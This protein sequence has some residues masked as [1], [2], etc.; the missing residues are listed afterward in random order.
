MPFQSGVLKRCVSCDAFVRDGAVVCPACRRSMDQAPAAIERTT[1]WLRLDELEVP[2]AYQRHQKDRLVRHIVRNYDEAQIGLLTVC[3][4]EDGRQW[5][6]DG[7]HRWLAL[8]EMGRTTALCEVLHRLSLERQAEVFSGRN[9][10]RIAVDHLDAFRAD[11]VAGKPEAVAIVALLRRHDYA[12]AFESRRPNAD[13]VICVTA[14]AEIH[15]WG[16]LDQTLEAVRGAWS[17]DGQATQAPLLQGVAAVLR[18]YPELDPRQLAA[19]CARHTAT[20]VLSRARM[21]RGAVRDGRPWAHVAAVLVE[22]HNHGRRANRLRPTD[23]PIG[24]ARDWKERG[25][26]GRGRRA[27]AA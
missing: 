1:E 12:I 26:D 15:A 9:K 23:I 5:L 2:K 14:L 25:D 19:S 8:C 4:S 16:V 22:I 20:E 7:Q 27:G 6:L 13:R 24:A 10:R 17:E 18:L 21:R 3:R 11:Q